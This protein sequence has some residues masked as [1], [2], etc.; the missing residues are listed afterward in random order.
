MKMHEY[1]SFLPLWITYQLPDLFNEF[2]FGT[3]MRDKNDVMK[4]ITG[5]K[6]IYQF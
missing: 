5:Y 1:Q 3:G 4:Y 6:K 2:D